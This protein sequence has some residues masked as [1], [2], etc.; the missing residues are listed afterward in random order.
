M[1]TGTNVVTLTGSPG[2]YSGL[3]DEVMIFH[4][5]LS[6][7]EIKRIYDAQKREK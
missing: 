5:P 7:T 3:M 1:K 6:A 2:F 4:R